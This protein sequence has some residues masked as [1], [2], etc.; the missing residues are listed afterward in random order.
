MMFEIVSFIQVVCG[1]IQTYL[2]LERYV[3]YPVVVPV[4]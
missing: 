1:L 3:N 2:K 4:A